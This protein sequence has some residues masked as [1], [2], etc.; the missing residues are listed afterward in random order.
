[1]LDRVVELAG[2]RGVSPAQIALA[3]LF[4][5]PAV[6]APIIGISQLTQLEEALTALEV[7]LDEGERARLEEP[8]Q[9]RQ[10]RGYI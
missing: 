9:P 8:Y 10:G 2:K 1:M 6:A 7:E 4:E 5:Q 3:W